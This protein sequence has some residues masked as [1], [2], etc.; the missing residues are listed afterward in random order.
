MK[1]AAFTAVEL[2]VVDRCGPK[3]CAV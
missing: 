2:L 3:R 1:L